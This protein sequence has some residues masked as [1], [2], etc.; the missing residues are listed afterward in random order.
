VR[1]RR[2]QYQ[3]IEPPQLPARFAA[4]GLPNDQLEEREVYTGLL[5]AGLNLSDQVAEDVIFEGSQL[6]QVAFSRT[7]LGSIQLHDVRLDSCDLAAATW[8][9]ATFNY[10]NP[11]SHI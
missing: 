4:S 9:K 3:G 1:G 6:K 2:Q 10:T 11:R 7:Q 8:E 5:V